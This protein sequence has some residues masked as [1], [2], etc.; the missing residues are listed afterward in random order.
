M[1]PTAKG[2]ARVLRRA[3]R[4]TR[5][6]ACVRVVQADRR[7]AQADPTP[8]RR[9]ARALADSLVDRTAQGR[10]FRRPWRGA[11]RWTKRAAADGGDL[12]LVPARRDGP[13]VRGCRV[14]AQG[15]ARF[16]IRSRARSGTTSSRCSGCNPGE[17]QARHIL[18]IPD[19]DSAGARAAHDQ[20]IAI[21][22]ALQQGRVVRFAAASLSRPRRGAGA[23]R[24]SDRFAGAPR[25]MAQPI[26][27]LD[28]GKTSQAF[29][30]PVAGASV[31]QQV[32][33]RAG[34]APHAG[35]TAQRTTTSRSRFARIVG[36]AAR[37]AGLH[38]SVARPDVRR[39]PRAVTRRVRLAITLGDPRGIG[40]E[41]TAAVLAAG[42]DAEITAIGAREQIADL[43]ADH[44]IATG[45]WRTADGPARADG[46]RSRPDR[47]PGDRAGRAP[48]PRAAKWTPSSPHRPRS[49]RC[50][51]PVFRF[52]DTPN[53]WRTSPAA[54]TSR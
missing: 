24:L 23:D 9:K 25:R 3:R 27:G 4:R 47:R 45:S 53:G 40:P 52:P 18:I 33:R 10:R 20:A 1:T 51:S 6:Y 14:L 22:A 44:R 46:S 21:S 35:R 32:G 8:T 12:E 38:Q 7:G 15:R 17:V 41:I 50:I 42:I 48:C 28:S 29:E 37:R 19:I 39:H 26:A 34:A 31:A 13:R 16:P 43:P 2:D 36:H 54:A 11:S 49:T 30:L 5:P